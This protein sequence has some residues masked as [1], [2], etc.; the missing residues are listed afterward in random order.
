MSADYLFDSAEIKKFI[1]DSLAEDL[2]SGDHSSLACIPADKRG[3]ARILMKEDGV[4]AGMEL[5]KR[6]L[7]TLDPDT[8][9]EVF[10]KDGDRVS[11]GETMA[12]AEGSVRALLAGE[13][14]LLTACSASAA[15]PPSPPK[16][17]ILCMIY[18]LNCSTPAKLHPVCA[19]WKN[20]P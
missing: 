19:C 18:R 12:L 14:L 16:R 8:S 7:L 15:S 20:G 1:A 6:I 3:T 4:L 9:L 13:R 17:S 5:A 11:K 2:G 10:A